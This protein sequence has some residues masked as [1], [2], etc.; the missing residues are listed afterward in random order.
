MPELLRVPTHGDE[1]H[2]YALRPRPK[3][4]FQT[5]LSA[6]DVIDPEGT[7]IARVSTRVG[8]EVSLEF[9]FPLK[10]GT[11]RETFTLRRE[12]ERL[13][14]ERLTRSV[15]DTD[16][17]RIRHEE[18]AFAADVIPLPQA[19]YPEVT[20]PFLLRWQPFDG[21]KRDLFA[22]INDR[23]VA[24]VEYVSKGETKVEVGGA[25]RKAIKLIMYPDFNDWVRLGKVLNKLA[26]PFVPKYHMWYSP[27]PPHDLL[28]FEGPFGPPG[29][30]EVLMELAD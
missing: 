9:E 13:A 24:R 20:L 22:W 25:K 11:I 21:K 7:R 30:P 28:R 14:A 5:V 12:G 6:D 1:E 15:Y 26:H 27:E 2:R 8:D 10:R 16:E 23:F 4:S 17:Q 18:I 29:A 19:V 3:S